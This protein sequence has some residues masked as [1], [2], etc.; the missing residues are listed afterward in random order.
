MCFRVCGQNPE[1]DPYQLEDIKRPEF[2]ILC[3]RVFQGD[4]IELLKESVQAFH[5]AAQ[6]EVWGYLGIVDMTPEARTTLYI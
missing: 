5:A 3:L 1:K 4:A 6:R 2:A